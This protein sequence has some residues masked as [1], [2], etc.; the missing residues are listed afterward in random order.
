MLSIQYPGVKIYDKDQA[1]LDALA[2][3]IGVGRGSLFYKNFTKTRKAAQASMRSQNAELA[4]SIVIQIVPYPGSTLG[5]M[6]AMVDS[7]LAE[8]EQRGVTD[9]DLARF[10]GDQRGKVYQFPGEHF[11]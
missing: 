7:T 5:A 1:A 8:F 4:G 2:F 3:I 6:K 10:K 9:D 11:G